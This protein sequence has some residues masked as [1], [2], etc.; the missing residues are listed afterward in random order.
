MQPSGLTGKGRR[1]EV[2]DF[3]R[4]SSEQLPRPFPVMCHCW[5]TSGV[6]GLGVPFSLLPVHPSLPPFLLS[7]SKYTLSDSYM[8]VVVLGIGNGE[9]DWTLCLP[10]RRLDPKRMTDDD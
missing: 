10:S 2:I 4:D 5:E 1:E 7:F 6:P 9:N 8:P 3:T